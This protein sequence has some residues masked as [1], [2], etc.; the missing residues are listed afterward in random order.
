MKGRTWFHVKIIYNAYLIHLTQNKYTYIYH[1]YTYTY[2]N[3]HIYMLSIKFSVVFK[4]ILSNLSKG[5]WKARLL[6]GSKLHSWT[7]WTFSKCRCKNFKKI[8]TPLESRW[9]LLWFW[10]LNHSIP[11]WNEKVMNE[12]GWLNLETRLVYT[13]V[14]KEKCTDRDTRPCIRPCIKKEDSDGC[15]AWIH[16]RVW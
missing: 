16:A 8:N 2:I 14:Y 13:A 3:I 6:L 9:K 12:T 1:S 7:I 4:W 11:I 10:L 15:T 5:V